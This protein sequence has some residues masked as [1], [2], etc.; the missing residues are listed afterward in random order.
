MPILVVGGIKGGS[1][2]ST[3]ASNLAVLRSRSGKRVLLVDADEQR[4]IS[5]W[6]EHRES[7]GVNTPWTTVNLLGASVRT[8]LLK[9]AKDYDDVIVDTGGR[10]TTSQR[11]A[12]TVAQFFLVPFQPRSLDVWTIGK[13]S[14]LLNEIKSINPKLKAFSVVNRGD[15]Q[16]S[17]NEGAA[18]ILKESEEL[19]HLSCIIGQRKAFSNATAEGLGVIE[20]KVKDKKA[21]SEIELLCSILFKT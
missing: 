17:D 7:L 20:L 4:S 10:D 18:D 16:G 21:I 2:K 15:S 3:L 14:A 6:S 1:G 19:T 9:M 5:D 13:V 11:S 12:L 8:Q